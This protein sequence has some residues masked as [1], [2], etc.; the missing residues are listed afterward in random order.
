MPEWPNRPT[1][2]TP[3]KTGRPDE[4]WLTRDAIGLLDKTLH[5]GTRVLEYGAGAST[6]WLARR[7]SWVD[8]VEHERPW[9][10]LVLEKMREGNVQNARVHHVPLEGDFEKYVTFG[11]ELHATFDLALVDGRQRVR[12]IKAIV[13][14]IYRGGLLVLDNAERPKYAEAHEF[15][16]DWQVERTDNGIWRTDIFRKP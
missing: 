3:D 8:S 12:C 5:R 13:D 6:I 16:R 7:V 4:P 11:R 10:D 2:H 14:C 15:L 9:V 1:W